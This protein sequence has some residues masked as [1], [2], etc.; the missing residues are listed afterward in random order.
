MKQTSSNSSF[1]NDFGCTLLKQVQSACAYIQKE[2]VHDSL[3]YM[4]SK[5]ETFSL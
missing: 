3:I 4:V 5:S 1:T 2:Y